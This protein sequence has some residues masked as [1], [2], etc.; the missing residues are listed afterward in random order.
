MLDLA[1]PPQ[2]VTALAIGERA[3]AALQ[4]CGGMLDVIKG[5]ETA[6]YRMAGGHV[7]W[8]GTRPRVNHPRAIVLAEL[9]PGDI[10]RVKLA[11][12]WPAPK[13]RPRLHAGDA[14][15][16]KLAAAA[17]MI[18]GRIDAFGDV[19]GFGAVLRGQAL[20][21]PLAEVFD[22]ACE[23]AAACGAGDWTRA[24]PIGR[25]LLG[26]GEGLTPSGDDFVGGVL[27]ALRLGARGERAAQV[28]TF[29]NRICEAAPKRTHIISATLLGDLSALRGYS[30]IDEVGLAAM[31]GSVSRVL[32]AGRALVTLGHSS[33]WDLLTGF[34]AGATGKFE[35]PKLVKKRK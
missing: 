10:R 23:F 4:G 19:K 35:A 13:R 29:A 7:V 6:P 22:K 24:Y 30:L 16:E 26:V 32:T 20:A 25:G 27:F 28:E 3:H 2:T 21:F 34:I 9:P 33:G 1:R 31:D 12:P 8:M 18:L 15:A 11:S 14:T 5:F 17:E